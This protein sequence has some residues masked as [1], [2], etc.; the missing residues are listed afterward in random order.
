MQVNGKF[1]M[2]FIPSTGGGA[3]IDE[4]VINNLLSNVQY[5]LNDVQDLRNTDANNSSRISNLESQT[6]N[7][8]AYIDEIGQKVNAIEVP[9]VVQIQET[10]HDEN[11]YDLSLPKIVETFDDHDVKNGYYY[12]RGN[13]G[14]LLT[15]PSGVTD[16]E[17]SWSLESYHRNHSGWNVT[18]QTLTKVNNMGNTNATIRIWK[19][20]LGMG[21]GGVTVSGQ[22]FE[23]TLT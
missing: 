7:I 6:N 4:T 20:I 9:Y 8:S 1:S 19:R 2:N 23:V 14:G 21:G 13:A 15:M 22:W 18:E 16:E 3:Q 11:D 10:G 17:S 12:W 5:L